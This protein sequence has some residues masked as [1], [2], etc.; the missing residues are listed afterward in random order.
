MYKSACTYYKF[1]YCIIVR[2]PSG[3][4]HRRGIMQYSTL[5]TVSH[6][7]SLVIHVCKTSYYYMYISITG[8]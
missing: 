6:I 2:F 3:L 7:Y 4:G 5:F 8:L 1:L